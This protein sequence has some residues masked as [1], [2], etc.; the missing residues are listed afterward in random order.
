[1]SAIDEGTQP[2]IPQRITGATT[3]PDYVDATAPTHTFQHGDIVTVTAGNHAGSLAV[4]V[5]PEEF[6]RWI[7]IKDTPQATSMVCLSFGVMA[8]LFMH[9]QHLTLHTPA[10][11][12]AAREVPGALG[13]TIAVFADGWDS[14]RLDSDGDGSGR[15][16]L[17]E[18]LVLVDAYRR[19]DRRWPGDRIALAAIVVLDDDAAAAVTDATPGDAPEEP[20]ALAADAP[21][22]AG[23]LV[24]VTSGGK[25]RDMLVRITE[26]TDS[27]AHGHHW[28][29]STSWL[30]AELERVPET[31]AERAAGRIPGSHDLGGPPAYFRAAPFEVD[32]RVIVTAEHHKDHGRRG[33]VV[34]VEDAMWPIGVRVGTGLGAVIHRFREDELALDMTGES[35][36]AR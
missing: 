30:L 12:L 26:V 29:G 9:A 1:M 13:Y 22:E 8:G 31:A 25:Y 7:A 32:D 24:R 21:L 27:L 33:V 23:E 34:S 5:P 6:P 3:T 36:A 14:P 15:H 20:P 18:A 28:N 11:A 4:V 17:A 2:Q 10:T 19:S 16:T 35:E